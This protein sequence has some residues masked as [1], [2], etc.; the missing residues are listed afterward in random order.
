MIKVKQLIDLKDFVAQLWY[1][2]FELKQ[3]L[4][5]N[6][7]VTWW[8]QMKYAIIIDNCEGQNISEIQLQVAFC[9][10]AP[11]AQG[12]GPLC[13]RT[14]T[15]RQMGQLAYT[16][17]WLALIIRIAILRDRLPRIAMQRAYECTNGQ[18]PLHMCAY[19]RTLHCRGGSS[20]ANCEAMPKPFML[21]CNIVT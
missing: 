17:S 9:N 1:K 12:P 13:V 20:Q 2:G 5:Q 21:Q 4:F 10:S 19:T 16:S 18:C 15:L 14:W 8:M 7:I 6:D 11:L 3:K